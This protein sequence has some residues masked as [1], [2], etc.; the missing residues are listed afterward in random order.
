MKSWLKAGRKGD[1]LLL[2]HVQ[3]GAASSHLAGEHGDA[4]KVRVAA[5]AVEG[6]ANAALI[7]YLAARLNLSRREVTIMQGD[8]SRRKTVRVEI[9]PDEVLRRLGE[10]G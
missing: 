3:P 5:P 10:R 6:A 9:D 4:L 8:K 1:A 7:E 2:I